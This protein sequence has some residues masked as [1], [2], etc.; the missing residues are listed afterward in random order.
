MFAKR[1]KTR[2]GKRYCQSHN[3]KSPAMTCAGTILTS[4]SSSAQETTTAH[5]LAGLRCVRCSSAGLL[6]NDQQME[7]PQCGTRYPVVTDVPIMFADAV[8]TPT[9]YAVSASFAQKL[10][11]QY[12]LSHFERPVVPAIQKIFSSTY[13]FGDFGIW[14]ESAQFLDR[15]RQSGMDVGQPDGSLE[16]AAARSPASDA[17]VNKTALIRYRWLVD[18]L[19]RRMQQGATISGNVRLE[20]LGPSTLS[21][22]HSQPIFVAYHWRDATGNMVVQDG[23]RTSLLVNVPPGRQLTQPMWITAPQMSGRY[24]LEITLVHEGVAWLDDHAK[25]IPVEVTTD[26]PP[27]RTLHWE[28]T[29]VANDDYRQDHLRALELIRHR[30]AQLG[31]V[32]PRILEVGG[33]S[34][35]TIAELKGDLYNV[36]VDAVGLQIGSLLAKYHGTGVKHLC[37]DAC[38]LPFAD[39]YFDCVAVFASLHHFPDLPAALRSMARTLKPGGFMAIMCEPVGHVFANAIPDGFHGELLRGVNEQSF[40]LDEYAQVFREAGLQAEEVIVD[41]SSSLKAF[42]TAAS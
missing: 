5:R 36:D 27:S 21:S 10:C 13:R 26:S 33:N 16:P 24:V 6:G 3:S 17:P 35:A 30:I 18:Y 37:A 34:Y 19:P 12:D 23:Q 2:D 14:T 25:L 28:I 31:F 15:V 1:N 8:I 20:N 42:L 9:P 38:V 40:S 32:E 4:L 7:C 11:A 22:Q 29:D 41:G 39:G